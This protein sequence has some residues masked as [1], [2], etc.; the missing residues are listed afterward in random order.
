M[1][2]RNKIKKLLYLFDEDFL[3][4]EEK[5]LLHDA[6]KSSPQLRKEKESFLEQR[7]LLKKNAA[8][9]FSPFF[10]DNVIKRVKNG[11]KRNGMDTFY[12]IL[13]SMFRRVA[14]AG[15]IIALAL[16]FFMVGMEDSL[17]HDEIFYMT[18]STLEEISH[19]SLF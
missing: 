2:R 16:I 14:I 17:S 12:E 10:A 5:S 3:S 19:L 4:D 18:D 1:A 6:L 11:K 7:E 13:V 15:A 9:G 8:S